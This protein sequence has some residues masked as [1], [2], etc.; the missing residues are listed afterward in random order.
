MPPPLDPDRD[1]N[2]LRLER[3]LVERCVSVLDGV[4]FRVRLNVGAFFM[5]L[6]AVVR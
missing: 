5:R 3:G 1:S 2:P 4:G 6:R